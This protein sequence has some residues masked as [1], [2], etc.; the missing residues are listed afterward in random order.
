[1]LEN[2]CEIKVA[3]TMCVF[4]ALLQINIMQFVFLNKLYCHTI[5]YNAMWLWQL[6]DLL[7]LKLQYS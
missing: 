3:S 1:M 4:Y 6:I 2:R 7:Y 5:L